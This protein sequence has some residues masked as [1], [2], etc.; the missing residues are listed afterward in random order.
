MSIF[1]VIISLI[2]CGGAADQTT[3]QI[4]ESERLEEQSVANYKIV[5]LE[6]SPETNFASDELS[7]YLFKATGKQIEILENIPFEEILNSK[8]YIVIGKINKQIKDRLGITTPI[9]S[10]KEAFIV[11]NFNGNLYILGS[12]N[13]ATIYG[14]Y[15][16]LEKY[17]GIKFLSKN[18]EYIPKNISKISI[19]IDEDLQVPRFIYREV[20]IGE[21]D[22]PDFALKLRDNGRLGHRN[23]LPLKFG[24]VFI[25]SAHDLVPKR[26]YA[27]KHPEYFC[28]GQLDYTLE[29]VKNIAL[30]NADEQLSKL[31]NS[32]NYYFVIG[33]RDIGSF[34]LNDT[35]RKR[36]NEGD[37]PA[38]PY[39]DFVS[40]IAKHL[41]RKYPNVTF[42]ASAY[43]WSI[44][45]PKNY[46]FLPS[47]MG[48]FFAPIGMDF[49]KP[50]VSP[51]NREFF[52]YLKGWIK[53][54][55]HV[56]IWH[57]ITNFNNYF[58]PYPNI[59]PIAK[60]LKTFSQFKRIEGVFL[61]GAYG[62]VTGD[63]SDL[64]LWVFSKLLWNPNRNVNQLI[65][66]FTNKYYGTGAPYIREYLKLM[67]DSIKKYPTPLFAKT[68]PS[69]PYL[70]L[71]FF[72]K[73][74][75]LFNKALNAVK[76]NIE[77]E[78][79]IKKAKLSVDTLLLLNKG[80]LEREAIEKGKPWFDD[81]YL[82]NLLVDIKETIK[83]ENIKGYSEGGKIEDFLN[84]LSL[85]RKA[86]EIPLEAIELKE[87][88]DWFDFQ[89]Y[90]L[91]N[92]C[93]T[94][95]EEDPL[96]SDG[97]AVSMPGNTPVWGIQM[98]LGF[99]PPEGKWKMYFRIRISLKNKDIGLID[100]VKFAFRY[101]VHPLTRGHFGL[102]T[103]FIDEEYHTVEVG[104]FKRNKN[105][106]LWI[107]PPNNDVVEKIYVDRVFIVKEN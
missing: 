92:C 44:K 100:K 97:V 79:H 52:K 63:L 32:T 85:E 28:G 81:K 91:T 21:G 70:N 66:E 55:K 90:V 10:K 68:P 101:G 107:A 76:G 67:Q 103:N 2:S 57:Y 33:H 35:S 30:K 82:Q 16:F 38:T 7:K 46:P 19:P 61:E 48:I 39:I 75:D 58:Q 88:K 99:L 18:Y 56:I 13:L 29:E 94:K 60:D 104:T 22:D 87:G 34:C 84:I 15:H 96:A 26:K 59:Y 93:G 37:S 89:E 105:A 95:L 65:E 12:S 31:D 47:N 83:R 62:R 27:K 23:S 49:S 50:I 43:Q 20:F 3:N 40:Y 45:P 53:L 5:L 9:P 51:E 74:E 14:V 1:L 72:I 106:G 64:K 86:S 54:T 102:I 77:L 25:K 17:V 11:K 73:A 80:K 36:I 69:V 24:N 6:S 78:N 41:K 98:N 42:L 71:E 4:I 8:D